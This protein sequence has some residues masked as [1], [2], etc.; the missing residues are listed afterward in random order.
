MHFLFFLQIIWIQNLTMHFIP[1]KYIYVLESITMP[2]LVP[3]WIFL[4]ERKVKDMMKVS[5]FFFVFS[6]HPLWS[7]F[8]I[9]HNAHP[10]R[11]EM[12][13]ETKGWSDS[14][15]YYKWYPFHRHVLLDHNDISNENLMIWPSIHNF[16]GSIFELWIRGLFPI[17]LSLQ[18]IISQKGTTQHKGPS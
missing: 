16:I 1:T 10:L 6:P 8:C 15:G 9:S 13:M 17:M 7:L 14:R 3:N 12:S 18:I 4:W 2:N 5:I 11:V